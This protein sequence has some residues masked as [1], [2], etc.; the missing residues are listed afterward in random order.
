[1]KHRTI[2]L[3]ATLSCVLGGCPASST[4]TQ[5]PAAA[6]WLNGDWEAT[7]AGTDQVVDG[8]LTITDG[9]VTEW[10]HGCDGDAMSIVSAPQATVS[11]A[12]AT[13]AVTVLNTDGA[14]LHITMRLAQ[15]NDDL[16]TGTINTVSLRL[17]PFI[18]A[19]TLQRR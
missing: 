4:S 15:V 17:A 13:V 8:C 11:D 5:D 16:L 7:A 10:G 3:V 12:G 6:T 9:K 1:M 14:L 18:G 19:V 2:L